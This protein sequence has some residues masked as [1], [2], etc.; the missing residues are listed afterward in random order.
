MLLCWICGKSIAFEDRKS[1][2][3]GRPVHENCYMATALGEVR[4]PFV[5]KAKASC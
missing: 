3:R 2:A 5:P 1:D 4:T